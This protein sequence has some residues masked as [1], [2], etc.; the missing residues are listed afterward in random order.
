[1]MPDHRAT[2][3]RVRTLALRAML[4]ASTADST[5][6]AAAGPLS[7]GE[8]AKIPGASPLFLESLSRLLEHLPASAGPLRLR[9][10]RSET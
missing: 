2:L 9:G 6:A 4:A 1:M 8:A 5:G 3:A 7:A 10:I